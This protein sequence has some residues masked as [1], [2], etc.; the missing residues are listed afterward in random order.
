MQKSKSILMLALTAVM[1][2]CLSLVCVNFTQ[3][4]TAKAEGGQYLSLDGKL[5]YVQDGK[6]QDETQYLIY[7]SSTVDLPHAEW[8]VYP[9]WDIVAKTD[10]GDLPVLAIYGCWDTK[11]F[12]L[13]FSVE[14]FNQVNPSTI[15]IE[16][17]TKAV[18]DT[19]TYTGEYAGIEFTSG[20]TL[21]KVEN[22]WTL[23]TPTPAPPTE[24]TY[25]QLESATYDFI[26]EAAPN[27]A[28]FFR[29]TVDLP[30][31]T[32]KW[33]AYK[34]SEVTVTTDKGN[35]KTIA[36]YGTDQSKL[37]GLY[38]NLESFSALAAKQIT[39]PAGTKIDAND[40]YKG[41][42]AGIEFKNAVTIYK[43]EGGWSHD[44]SVSYDE[45]AIDLATANISFTYSA[46]FKRI[47]FS[48]PSVCDKFDAWK[49]LSG[50][51]T[52][53]VEYGDGDKAVSVVQSNPD[54]KGLLIIVNDNDGKIYQD[55]EYITLKSATLYAED[56]KLKI[57]L[58]NSRTFSKD[59]EFKELGN[60]TFQQTTGNNNLGFLST[61]EYTVPMDSAWEI[62]DDFQVTAYKA[63]GTSEQVIAYLQNADAGHQNWLY[64]WIKGKTQEQ[65]ADYTKI[66][67]AKDTTVTRDYGWKKGVKFSAKDVNYYNFEGSWG[68]T[69]PST[70]VKEVV[71]FSYIHNEWNNMTGSSY[72]TYCTLLTFS[73]NI[74]VSNGSLVRENRRASILVNGQTTTAEQL[75][76]SHAHGKNTLLICINDEELMVE[77]TTIELLSGFGF[78]TATLGE[79]VKLELTKEGDKWVFVVASNE[80][81]KPLFTYSAMLGEQEVEVVNNEI[82]F[83]RTEGE[84]FDLEG[85]AVTITDKDEKSYTAKVEGD[86]DAALAE[87]KY[88]YNAA[89][90]A[91]N[92]YSVL[93]KFDTTYG[94]VTVT[95]KLVVN[96]KD[97]VA[98]VI[99]WEAGTE[100]TLDEGYDVSMI[101]VSATDDVDGEVEVVR[102][103]SE[104]AVVDGLL[105]AG[106]H[107]L[108]LTAT[109]AAGNKAEIVINVTVE[110][111]SEPVTSEPITSDTSSPAQSDSESSGSNSESG[112]GC[113]CVSLVDGSIIYISF[114]LIVASLVCAVIKKEKR[115]K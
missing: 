25:L 90:G 33:Y 58:K 69:D 8:G 64:I 95:V 50:T 96:E 26:S 9:T 82:L 18:V 77:G 30:H 93:Y 10:K 98:P 21:T 15:T 68:T 62:F 56:Y 108:T 31:L 76:Y 60:V 4:Q 74:A 42:Y 100:L 49:S 35:L 11:T 43:T 5:S 57:V 87:G 114:L 52:F 45:V 112:S 84:A 75:T 40:N 89:E 106:Q 27:Y 115:A 23:S 22:G 102:T 41:Q 85:L 103:W 39:I 88:I 65:L 111:S 109:D 6:N 12:A 66:T 28:I 107:T 48:I 17:G 110:G 70:I 67:V 113:D 59:T 38:F 99:E 3:P 1:S 94:W 79:G 14:K 47:Q 80:G 20:L 24:R 51:T 16:A 7:L 72:G 2:L 73:S 81:M 92:Q 46:Q 29:T 36:V 13:Y 105:V 44:E 101:N 78:E 83:E 55:S 104:G 97:S 19:T 63:D 61:C 54:D 91:E 37:F 86:F 53:F 71:K 34:T 32:D